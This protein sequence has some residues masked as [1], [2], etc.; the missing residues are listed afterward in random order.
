MAGIGFDAQIVR[1]VNS[2]WKKLFGMA[3][4][5][6][7]ALRQL[8]QAPLR[9]FLLIDGQTRRQVTFAC[10]SRAKYY[11]PIRMIPEADIL[12]NQFYV[13]CF[14]SSNPFRYLFYTAALLTN[15]QSRLPDFSGFAAQEVRCEQLSVNGY[16][17]YLQ[18]DGESAGELPCTIAVVPDELSLMFPPT[19]TKSE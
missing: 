3:T 11:G 14:S 18:V 16:K 13:Y 12:S 17:T 6:M 19:I 15:L 8:A 4:Y 9:P 1:N 10:I 2:Q 5:F 7:E